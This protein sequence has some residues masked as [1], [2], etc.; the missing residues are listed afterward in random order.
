MANDVKQPSLVV[1][2]GP[3]AAGKSALALELASALAAEIVSADSRQVYR[4]LDIGTAKPDAAERASCPH[5]L[6]DVA[7]PNAGFDVAR[8]VELARVAITGCHA[9]GRQPLVVGGTG[10]YLR[11]LCGGLAPVAG[12]DP[13]LRQQLESEIAA[14]GLAALH[15]RLA[16]I[17]PLTAQ[18][19]PPADRVRIVRALEVHAL[20]G[21]PLSEQQLA[22]GFADRPY[23]VLWLVVD[24][25]PAVLRQRIAARCERMFE[26]GLVDEA[27]ALR[28][29][30]GAIPLLDTIG[31]REALQLADGTLDRARAI[32]GATTRTCQYAK[33]QR[34]WLRREP[35]DHWSI[36]PTAAELRS[37]VEPFLAADAAVPLPSA[38]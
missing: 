11:A 29:R 37:L 20:T 16:A 19:V 18:R 38:P 13:Q 25:P 5:H 6:L 8:F 7:D 31:Y 34:T 23:R 3:T 15:R 9:R 21:R 17:D 32:A 35:V 28:Q 33:R 10:L 24:R 30:W 14:H 36:D 12:R 1:I 4:G 2:A 22:H 26:C 27:R